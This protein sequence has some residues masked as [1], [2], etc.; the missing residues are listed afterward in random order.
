MP[1]YEYVCRRCD[2]PFETLVRRFG[3]PV[4]CPH[5]T[6]RE[7]DR[8]LSVPGCREAACDASCGTGPCGVVGC[9]LPR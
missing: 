4:S 2:R 8:Q 1:I 6:S 3:D 9:G 7:I 5:C